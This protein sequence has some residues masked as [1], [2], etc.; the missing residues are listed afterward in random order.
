MR[1]DSHSNGMLPSSEGESVIERA[2]RISE[3]E[4]K[5]E[6]RTGGFSESEHLDVVRS[7]AADLSS[8]EKFKLF[9]SLTD[10]TGNLTPKKPSPR[11]IPLFFGSWSGMNPFRFVK[12]FFV[13]RR[14]DPR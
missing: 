3:R 9:D 2:M 5:R 13:S 1:D 4:H 8:Q 6:S 12:P 10:T 14:K 7:G 11:P